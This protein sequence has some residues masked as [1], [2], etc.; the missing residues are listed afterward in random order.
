MDA[1]DFIRTVDNW[2]ANGGPFPEIGEHDL[3]TAAE[4]EALCRAVASP[5]IYT[6]GEFGTL[7][8]F[9]LMD[10]FQASES[11]EAS[12]YL[13]DHGLP[14][15]RKILISAL[16]DAKPDSSKPDSIE[17]LERR[18]AH[19]FVVKVLCAYQQRGDAALIVQAA[20]DP[21]LAGGYLWGTIFGMTAERHPEAADICRRLADPLPGGE[22]VTPYLDFA[23]RLA[24][25]GAIARH[26]FD[27]A[28]GFVRLSALLADRDADNN[29]SAV[30]A[31]SSIPFLD[32]SVREILLELASQHPDGF[33]RL[34]EAWVRAKLGHESGRGRLVEFCR[35]PSYSERAAG[36]LD[37][38]GLG[39]L[40]PP[41]THEP[42][43]VAL[44]EM[45][46]W[47][48]HPMEFGRPPDEIAQ[49]DTR[50]LN[51]PPTGQR[52]RFWLFKF[53]YEARDGQPAHDS[54]GL[55]GSDTFALDRTSATLAPEDVYGLHCCFEMQGDP[56]IPKEPPEWLAGAGRRLIAEINPGFAAA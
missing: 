14:I 5:H 24:R 54:I 52:H 39:D 38:L 34:E 2:T 44:A 32:P 4:A 53:H 33:V 9:D 29:G 31:A 6:P 3:T 36:Y 12:F 8:L 41:E 23:N 18:K 45:C 30:A 49:Y 27:S 43:F 13:R 51:W 10:C 42:D 15:L 20:R 1:G 19:L 56:R 11:R 40:I 48:S 35:D 55:V 47:L 28:A 26:P 37:E 16:R 21:D 46:R 17:M 50:E 7:A 25:E 22:I